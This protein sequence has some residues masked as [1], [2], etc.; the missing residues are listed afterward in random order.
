MSDVNGAVELY[1]KVGGMNT[2]QFLWLQ[3]AKMK[4]ESYC[5]PPPLD[6]KETK[7]LAW[8]TSL[9][10]THSRQIRQ[11]VGEELSVSQPPQGQSVY[12]YSKSIVSSSTWR[13]Y[14]SFFSH[15]K[16]IL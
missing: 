9:H 5:P 7:R 16:P 11:G 15:P 8:G 6:H 1:V 10:S 2:Q 12:D 13:E 4:E 14:N 3:G